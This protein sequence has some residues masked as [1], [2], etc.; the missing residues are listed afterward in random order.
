MFFYD[1]GYMILT[2][3]GMGLIFLPQLW[4][5]NT[6]KEY[7]EV[8]ARLGISGA[9]LAR[10]LLRKNNIHDVEV[11]STPG[12]LSDHYDPSVKKV[13]LSEPNYHGHSIAGL[14]IAAHEVG[15]AIQHNQGYIPVVIRGKLF[16]LANLGSQFGPM[17]VM[18][19]L[20][21]AAMSG[22]MPDLAWML[23]WVG[24]IVFAM[25][26]AFHLVTLPVEIDASTRAM[27]AL[28]VGYYLKE[29]ELP[30]AKKVLTA[31]AAT[32]VA[33]ALYSLMQLA[34]WVFRVMNSRR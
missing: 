13:R 25:S 30:G 27:E 8:P 12:E 24:V 28:K 9:D 17:L 14:A 32:Y 23:A 1:P 15:H 19:S 6:V 31:A 2:V 33:T 5:K 18:I 3:V 22:A 10:E 26:V 16:P 34:Y 7:R 20:G 29:D 21:L 4:V 11:E